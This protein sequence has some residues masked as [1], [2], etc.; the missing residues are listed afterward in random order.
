MQDHPSTTHLSNG[1]SSHSPGH[2]PIFASLSG[3]SITIQE[4]ET[5]L[6]AASEGPSIPAISNTAVASNPIG[7][8]PPASTIV[9]GAA[10]LGSKNTSITSTLRLP[11]APLTEG[12]HL[13]TSNESI[14]T[15]APVSI[16]DTHAPINKTDVQLPTDRDGLASSVLEHHTHTSSSSYMAPNKRD[17]S[18]LVGNMQVSGSADTIVDRQSDGALTGVRKKDHHDLVLSDTNSARSLTERNEDDDLSK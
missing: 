6:S 8:V 10:H 13:S 17:T 3:H 12:D 5:G 2:A 14:I 7:D 4:A 16:G 1:H 15:T 11:S 9:N 18:V